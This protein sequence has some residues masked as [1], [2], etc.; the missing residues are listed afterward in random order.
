[1][2]PNFDFYDGFLKG[3]N[4][5]IVHAIIGFGLDFVPSTLVNILYTI[6]RILTNY[7]NSG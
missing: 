5:M 7:I 3:C 2:E 4:F 6:V 1:M